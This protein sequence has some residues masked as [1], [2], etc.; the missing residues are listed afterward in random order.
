MQLQLV[1]LPASREEEEK[2]EYL[3]TVEFII[4]NSTGIRLLY[5]Q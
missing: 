1:R 2:Y 3:M 5:K 4:N